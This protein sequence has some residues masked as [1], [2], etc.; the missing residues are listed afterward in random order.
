MFILKLQNYFKLF[1]IFLSFFYGAQGASPNKIINIY[2]GN[3]SDKVRIVF[4]SKKPITLLKA[5]IEPGNFLTI[6]IK[7]VAYNRN[8]I[9]LKNSIF[10]KNT[11]S[12]NRINGNFIFKVK[13]KGKSKII[14]RGSITKGTY[15]LFIDLKKTKKTV[16]FKKKKPVILIDAGHGGK[17][18]G[19]I[20]NKKKI[21]E[22]DITLKYAK[23]LQQIL[24]KSQKFKAILTRKKDVFIP[25]RD[26]VKLTKK[27][28][29]DL[30]ISIHADSAPNKKARGASVYTLSQK[31]SDKEAKALA[32]RENKADIIH[33]VKVKDEVLDVLVRLSQRN[34]MNQSAKFAK[35]LNRHL[36]KNKI[37]ILHGHSF[38]NFRVLKSIQ[39]PSILLELGFISNKYDEKHIA[40]NFYMKKIMNATADAVKQFIK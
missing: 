37:N 5:K 30:F 3:H 38:A 16:T 7:N 17:D 10:H 2:D 28:D 27:Y 33:G 4:E 9:N 35:I 8:I 40:G 1:A 36:K 11:A 12:L 39:T 21:K 13:L 29:A 23:K 32:A 18:P 20:S 26:R 34:A 6:K 14:R 15:R 24:N 22:K 31:S 19:A 25:L